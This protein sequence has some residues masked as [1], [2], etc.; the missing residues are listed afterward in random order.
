M[1][2][3]S[4]SA[5]VRAHAPLLTLAAVAVIGYACTAERSP[6]DPLDFA[7]AVTDVPLEVTVVAPDGKTPVAGASVR[8]YTAAGPVATSALTNSSGVAILNLAQGDYCLSARTAPAGWSA[9]AVVAPF[10][11]PTAITNLADP[12]GPVVRNGRRYVP[13]SETTFRECY[14]TVPV[15]VGRNGGKETVEMAAPLNV[16]LRVLGVNANQ[17]DGVNVYAVIPLPGGVDWIAPTPN[18]DFKL[19]FLSGLVKTTGTGRVTV[20]VSKNVPFYLEF[21]QESGGFFLT[22]TFRGS[23]T[24]SDLDLVLEASPLMCVQTLGEGVETGAPGLDF[25]KVNF[26]YSA[27]P[28]AS[29]DSDVTQ[30]ALVLDV[31]SAG[32]NTVAV[33]VLHRGTGPVTLTFRT[34]LAQGRHTTTIDFA[35][36]GVDCSAA[37]TK[38]TGPGNAQVAAVY[39]LTKD[40]S[41]GLV[42][43]TVVLSNIASA[44]TAVLFAAKT[45]GDALPIA[46]RSD[47]TD[48]F[49]YIQKPTACVVALSNDDKWS[50][51]DI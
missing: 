6:T 49:Y 17:L 16:D 15:R 4:R 28:N 10:A 14:R 31:G 21:Q 46:S 38:T 7:A 40:A 37:T 29:A 32:S 51:G 3:S 18:S 33:E 34:D 39:H 42:K 35:C 30:P 36:T 23:A 44:H 12:Y 47:A 1:V 26:G 45:P 48:A 19:G 20:P 41:T 24:G 11:A 43:T 25:T 13:F 8:A 50:V 9:I 22:G 2:P 27:R 5:R